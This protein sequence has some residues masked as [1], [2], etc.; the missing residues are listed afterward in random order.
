[1]LPNNLP[2]MQENESIDWATHPEFD[3]EYVTVLEKIGELLWLALEPFTQNGELC[4][5][6]CSPF[7]LKGAWILGI[8]QHMYCFDGGKE[9]MSTM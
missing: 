3:W 4:F 9:E 5:I 7:G 6:C 1:M 8:C 2:K